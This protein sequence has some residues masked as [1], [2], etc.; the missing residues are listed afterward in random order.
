MGKKG[1]E[2]LSNLLK[3]KQDKTSNQVL[4]ILLLSPHQEESGKWYYY[5]LIFNASP[6]PLELESKTWQIR[7]GFIE[8]LALF[9][10]FTISF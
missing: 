7:E 2:R 9:S 1:R 6:L 4:F 8:P 10:L 5:I 3:G